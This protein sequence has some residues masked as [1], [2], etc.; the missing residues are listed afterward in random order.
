MSISYDNA[1]ELFNLGE[2][3]EIRRTADLSDASVRQLSV[4]H[5]LLVAHALALLGDTQLAIR[6]TRFVDQP[7]SSPLIRSQLHFVLGL[8]NET[9]GATADALSH[10]QTALRFAIA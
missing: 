4:P 8:T 10:F 6:V 7:S 3:D 1:E 2:F 9:S 5:R